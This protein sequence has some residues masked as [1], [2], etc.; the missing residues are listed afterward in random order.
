MMVIIPYLNVMLPIVVLVRQSWYRCTLALQRETT[1]LIISRWVSRLPPCVI[2]KYQSVLVA[3]PGMKAWGRTVASVMSSCQA[4]PQCQCQTNYWLS[5]ILLSQYWNTPWQVTF[6]REQTLAVRSGVKCV[7]RSALSVW[8][9][10]YNSEYSSLSLTVTCGLGF[11]FTNV[12]RGY[13]VTV[14]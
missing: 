1:C 10:H 7:P 6:N 5:K 4:Q 8:V 2:C 14:W 13:W 9:L 11:N 3:V 12:L